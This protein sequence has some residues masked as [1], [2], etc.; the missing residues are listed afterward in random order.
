MRLSVEPLE[1]ALAQFDIPTEAMTPQ[2][3]AAM[4]KARFN[5]F[6][7]LWQADEIACNVLRLHPFVVWGEEY[8]ALVWHDGDVL[9]AQEREAA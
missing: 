8:E 7:T 4:R 2:Q 5:G 1:N 3:Q 6:I 9:N